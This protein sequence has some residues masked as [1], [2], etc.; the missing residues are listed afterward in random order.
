MLVGPTAFGKPDGFRQGSELTD[1]LDT[2]LSIVETRQR[3][4]HWLQP[5]DLEVEAMSFI[6]NDRS[7]LSISSDHRRGPMVVFCDGLAFRLNPNTDPKIVQS[8]VT[9][10]G[11]EVIER[12]Q[13]VLNGILIAP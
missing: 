3:N 4:I 2:T 11:G 6:V 10:N 13:L 5:I 1:G 7:D 9:I 8:L 12:D